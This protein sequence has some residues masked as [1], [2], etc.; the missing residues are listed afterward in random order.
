MNTNQHTKRNF[1]KTFGR[2]V[3]TIYSG[4]SNYKYR[5][6]KSLNDSNTVVVIRF[7]R[8]FEASDF[9]RSVI[10]EGPQNYAY[11]LRGTATDE[12]K[13]WTLKDAA[14][15][16]ERRVTRGYEVL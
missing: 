8:D 16:V 3:V 12:F 6:F 9:I 10:G 2:F 4:S 11:E 1:D 15:F 14:E 7:E 5:V 13:G